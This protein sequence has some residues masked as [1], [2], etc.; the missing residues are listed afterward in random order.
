MDNNV[1][2]EL[3]CRAREAN[4]KVNQSD[5]AGLYDIYWVGGDMFNTANSMMGGA[6]AGLLQLRD[7]NNGENFY[8][9]VEKGGL[10]T[11]TV[12]YTHLTLPTIRLV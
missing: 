8:G 10:G 5:V 4:N 12:S 6:L 9:T 7:G 3:E 2:N 1:R 11:T